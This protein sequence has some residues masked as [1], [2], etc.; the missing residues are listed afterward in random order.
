VLGKFVGYCNDAKRELDQCFKLEK[1]VKRSENLKKAREFDA[2]Y[3]E[4][5]RAR[6]AAQAQKQSGTAD[7]SS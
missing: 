2:I 6:A 3:E 1:N 5:K 7:S 4:S